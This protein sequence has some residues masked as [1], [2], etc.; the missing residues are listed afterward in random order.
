MITVGRGSWGSFRADQRTVTILAASRQ[1]SVLVIV[2]A[3]ILTAGARLPLARAPR[4]G[5][6]VNSSVGV[7]VNSSTAPA[8]DASSGR[9]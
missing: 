9:F 2:L 5:V 8:W 7:G 6:G 4:R 3:A 1:S